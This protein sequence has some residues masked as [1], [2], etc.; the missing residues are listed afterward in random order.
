MIVAMKKA[1]VIVREADR[2]AALERLREM[3]VMHLET[4]QASS[5]ALSVLLERRRVLETASNILKSQKPPA[6]SALIA[7]TADAEVTARR[8]LSLMEE[9]RNLLDEQGRIAKD[10]ERLLP[11]GEF[12]PEG[13]LF[14]RSHGVPLR[15]F[16]FPPKLEARLPKEIGRLRLRRSGKL[17]RAAM[18][19]T[20]DQS[21]PEGFEEVPLAQTGIAGMRRQA[22]EARSRIGAIGGELASLAAEHKAIEERKSA[23]AGQIEFEAARTGM[24]S[25]EGSLAWLSGFIPAR[26]AK[27]L[28]SAAARDGWAA[29]VTDPAPGEAVPTLV[30]NNRFVR[31]IQPVF[32]ALAIVPGYREY[33]ISVWFLLFFTAFFGM[34]IGDA[35]YGTILLAASGWMALQKKRAG[36]RVPDMVRLLIL[37]SCS[38]IAWGAVTGTWFSVAPAALP[39]PL[40]AL[41]LPFFDPSR[42]DPKLVQQNIMQFCFLLAVIQLCVAHLKNIRRDF[43]GLKF[44]AQIGWLMMVVGLYFLVMNM[45]VDKV[46]FPMPQWSVVVIGIGFVLYFVFG[47]Q[48]GHFLKGVLASC[49]NF[50]PTFL[51]AVSCFA[52]IIS[53]IRLFAVGLAGM[54]ISQTVNGMVMSMPPGVVRI[55][56]GTLLL[57][58]GHTLNLVLSILSVVVHGIRLNML[59]FSG[60]LGMEWSGTAYKPFASQSK[61]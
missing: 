58:F 12:D 39:W 61:R 4:G 10:I 40:R 55:A 27:D 42:S 30:E 22:E 32:D 25:E 28:L 19:M 37:L 47:N 31:L 33:E 59:E 9:R 49:I 45:V 18:L 5:E 34:I 21:L 24:M 38:T 2:Q 29:L 56:G 7:G 35:A 54:A 8:V 41:V 3:G 50:I 44:I 52:D 16:E 13:V 11:W 53:Y 23:L 15:L 60:H 14:L 6:E 57:C 36:L 46:R 51:G 17:V 1:A 48:E 20:E 43:P 26:G